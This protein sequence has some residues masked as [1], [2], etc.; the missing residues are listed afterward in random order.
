VAP[1]RIE[2]GAEQ[3]LAGDDAFLGESPFS[4][5]R[6]RDVAWINQMRLMWEDINYNWQRWVLGYRSEQ[7]LGL[8]QRWF[9]SLDWQ[10]VALVIVGSGGLLLGLLALWLF[11]PWQRERDP[12]QR[13]LQR[14]EALLL[15]H[16]VRRDKGEGVH[17]FAARAA[18]LMPLQ[19]RAISAFAQAFEAQR[20]AG[21]PQSTDQLKALLR[22][23]RRELPWRPLRG[24]H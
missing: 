22:R 21:Q 2:L 14:Y 4:P 3:A 15:R 1:E 5:L 7:Q 23:L 10:R 8:L 20:Y 18:G 9:G 13:L 24:Q 12:Q 6:Y 17:A 11:K 16:G 19:A